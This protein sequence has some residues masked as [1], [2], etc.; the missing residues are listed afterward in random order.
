MCVK[1]KIDEV[2]IDWLTAATWDDYK[3]RSVAFSWQSRQLRLDD[4]GEGAKRKDSKF[5]QYKGYVMAG[6]FFGTAVQGEESHYVVRASGDVAHEFATAVRLTGWRVTR[7][8]IQLTVDM[9]KIYNSLAVMEQLEDAEWK[10]RKPEVSLQANSSGMDTVYIG[11]R[12]SESFVRQYVKQ[13]SE[14]YR[15]LR[16]EMELK[17]DKASYAWSE[18]AKDPSVI[19]R[20]LKA[21]LDGI[22][23]GVWGVE[24][25]KHRLA[26]VMAQRVK[27]RYV[28]SS[29]RILGWLEIQV[30]PAIRKW[31]HEHEMGP[32][33]RQWL[34][35]MNKE[36]NGE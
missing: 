21:S 13:D 27:G 17:G 9:P 33:I 32:A 1:M 4:D 19:G 30:G 12:A 22:P 24:M 26:G 18:F 23:S 28:R 3:F 25:F 15:Y 31:A 2:R 7:M 8:D 20:F 5:M 34:Y 36:I 11:S 10:G 14:G 29:G 35:E 16:Y 6:V